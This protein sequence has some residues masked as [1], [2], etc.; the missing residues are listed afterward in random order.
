MYSPKV[1]E[2]DNKVELFAFI[3]QWSFGDLITTCDGELF[4]NHVPFI[5]D[6]TSNKLYGH[7]AINNP[8][9]KM[10]EKTH[11]LI[12]VFNGVNCYISPSWYVSQEMVP[13]WNFEAV[14]VSGKA[15]LV[16]DERLLTILEKLTEKHEGQFEKPWTMDKVSDAKLS[17]MMKMIVGFE[18]DIC[19][20]KG[21]SKMSQN[22]SVEDRAGVISGLK[23]QTDS[24]SLLIA[25][26]MALNL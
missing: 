7:F 16:D 19:S 3:E 18:I 12:V 4:V 11:D 15:R 1:F 17:M 25:D 5:L 9:V 8:Q 26:K 22:R 13:T 23:N 10:I 24:M 2:M 20:I 6:Q 21:K 14:H